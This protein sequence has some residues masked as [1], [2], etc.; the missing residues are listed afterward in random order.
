MKHP[1]SG[2]I[3]LLSLILLSTDAV[4]QGRLAAALDSLPHAKKIDQAAISP[5]GTQV[6][7]IVEGELSMAA[8]MGGTPH[9]I[10]ADQKLTARDV[11]WSVDSRHIAWLADLAAEAPS[12]QLW[13]ASRDGSG[14]VKFADLKGYAQTPHYSP[15]GSKIAVLY[16]EDMPRVAGPLQPMTPLAGVV[17]EKIYERMFT[18]TNMTGRLTQRAGRRLPRTD[19]VTTTGGSRVCTPS[20]QKTVKCARS[21]SRSGRSRSHMF[22][23]MEN[24]WPL[25]KG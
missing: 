8:V 16:M 21:I 24:Q 2:F 14:L 6:A 10:A 7:Y 20:T 9:R 11:T 23:P 4:A 12:S 22:L 25:S 5:D 3:L 18:S 1:R 13:A 17:G 19:R 15:D